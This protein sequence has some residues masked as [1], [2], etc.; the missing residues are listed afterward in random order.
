MSL[1]LPLLLACGTAGITLDG[2]KDPGEDLDGDSGVTDDPGPT[3]DDTGSTDPSRWE[4]ARLVITSPASGA[5]LPYGEP[6]GFSAT[7]YDGAGS[8]TDFDEIEWTSD[9]DAGWGLVGASLDDDSLDVGTHAITATARLPNGDRLATTVGG[10]LVQ[11]VYT[12]VYSGTLTVNIAYDAYAVGCA[13]GAS[14]V[15]DEYGESGAGDASCVLSLSGYEVDASFL[16]DLAIEA[17][18]VTG[19]SAA[20]LYITTYDFDTTGAVDEDGHL[21]GAFADDIY[22]Y[23]Q[24][25]GT[26]D[27]VRVSRDVSG[28]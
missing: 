13:G 15:V 4:E 20:D 8:P 27:L 22:G 18:D 3:P 14:L 17:G 1:V 2:V 5:F 19:T 24:V 23:L 11:S 28:Y 26:M 12:G 25:D 16:F 10:V 7:V 9:I 21:S 6:A